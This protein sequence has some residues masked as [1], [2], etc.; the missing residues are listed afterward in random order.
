MQ[1][2]QKGGLGIETAFLYA[3][4]SFDLYGWHVLKGQKLK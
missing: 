1:G 2:I 4:H 3:L